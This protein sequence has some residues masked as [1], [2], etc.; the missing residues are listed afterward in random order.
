MRFSLLVPCSSDR[1]LA[2]LDETIISLREQSMPDWELVIAGEASLATGLS[3]RSRRWIA[4]D[5]RVHVV[6]LDSGAGYAHA[7]SAAFERSSGELVAVVDAGDMLARSALECAGSFIDA[8]PAPDCWYTDE[9]EVDADGLYYRAFYKPDWSPERLRSQHYVGG[10]FIIRR[11]LLEPAGEVPGIPLADLQPGAEAY[12][13]ALRVTERSAAVGHIPGALYHRRRSERTAV[14]DDDAAKLAVERHLRAQGIEAD[15][16]VDR[17]THTYSLRRTLASTPLI[18]FVIPTRGSVGR[19]WGTDRV[20]VTEAVRSIVERCSYDNYELVVVVDDATPPAVLGGLQDIAGQRL[21]LVPYDRRFNF[22]E[23]IN[24]GRRHATGELLLL[25]NDDMEVISDD[26]LET[27]AALALE[28]D[29]GAVGAKLLLADGRLQHGG[30]V[31][32]G[33]P[34]H[35]LWGRHRDDPGPFGLLSVQR[36]CIGVTAAC[37]MTRT[38]VFDEVGGFAEFFPIDFNDVDFALKLRKLGYRAIWTPAAQ[39]YHFETQTRD[40]VSKPEDVSTMYALWDDELHHDP[41]FNVNLAPRRDDWV[42]LG[43]R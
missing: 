31:Y 28:P 38:E 11:Q 36:E 19:V 42:E 15:V 5:P 35:I 20:F 9:D 3:R 6:H 2:L 4:T 34:H 18:S 14:P 7:L 37:L 27:M 13:L 17:E 22:S 1:E 41:Y 40:K 21:H 39:L 23:K 26:F 33:E 24:L 10:L 29:V 12:D 8:G 16:T 25:F 43:L 30:H 32:N